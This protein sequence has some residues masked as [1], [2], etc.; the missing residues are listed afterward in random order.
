ML[1]RI[2]RIGGGCYG[3]SS[4]SNPSLFMKYILCYSFFAQHLTL[5]LCHIVPNMALKQFVGIC[6]NE[7]CINVSFLILKNPNASILYELRSV[8]CTY[9]LCC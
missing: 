3:S 6:L 4:I 7:E 5:R 8:P 2:T 9:S 1:A